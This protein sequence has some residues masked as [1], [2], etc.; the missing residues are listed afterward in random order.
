M[1]FEYTAPLS[2]DSVNRDAS[3]GHAVPSSLDSDS[4]A[5]I[6]SSSGSLAY[7]SETLSD[8]LPVYSSFFD[9]FVNYSGPFSDPNY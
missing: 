2:P 8:D 3:L 7:P 6:V 9:D 1:P 4:V 5:P